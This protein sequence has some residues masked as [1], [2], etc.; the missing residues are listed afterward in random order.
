VALSPVIVFSLPQGNP[1]A[2]LVIFDFSASYSAINASILAYSSS[3][4]AFASSSFLFV[5]AAAA[6]S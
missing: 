5:S 6:A 2:P 4:F 3:S 1:S